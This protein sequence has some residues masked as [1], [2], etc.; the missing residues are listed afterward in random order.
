LGKSDRAVPRSLAEE[1]STMR[2]KQTEKGRRSGGISERLSVRCR[3]LKKN[4]V[5][6]GGGGGDRFSSL[7]W[8]EISVEKK[9]DIK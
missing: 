9:R 4:G 8:R 7:R 2:R 1:F 5:E 3:V 6:G